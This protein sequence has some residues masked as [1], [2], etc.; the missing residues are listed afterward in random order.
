MAFVAHR[1]G[2]PKAA[3]RGGTAKAQRTAVADG[4]MA[5]L[6]AAVDEVLLGLGEDITKVK[7]QT[8]TTYQRMQNCACL[9]PPKRGKLL[10]YLKADPAEVDLLAGFARGVAG[11]GHQGTGNLELTLQSER[12]LERAAE[13]VPAS[14]PR[15]RTRPISRR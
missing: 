11:L 3:R 14:A 12:D 10:V 8:Y 15:R 5:E 2:P 13:Y 7:N 9:C 1:T 6:A 4:A